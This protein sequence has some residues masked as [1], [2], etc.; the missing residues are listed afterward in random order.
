[1]TITT[2]P[3]HA[4]G[5]IRYKKIKPYPPSVEVNVDADM[6]TNVKLTNSSHYMQFGG[7]EKYCEFTGEKRMEFANQITDDYASTRGGCSSSNNRKEPSRITSTGTRIQLILLDEANHR[8]SFTIGSST[9]LKA[10]FNDYSHE[11]GISLRSL[12]FSHHGR[13]LFLSSVGKKTPEELNMSDQDIIDVF[14]VS[15]A[16]DDTT[17]SSQGSKKVSSRTARKPK[18]TTKKPK[19]NGKKK[20]KQNNQRESTKSLEEYKVEHS[21]VLSKLHKEAEPTL[22]EIRTRLNSLDLY[23]QPPK[24]KKSKRRS[25]SNQE[26]SSNNQ[27]LP[28]SGVGGKAGKPCYSVQVGEVQNLYKTSKKPSQSEN[29]RSNNSSTLDLHGYT[30]KEAITKL[31]ENLTTWVDTAMQGYYPFVMQVKIICGCGNQLLSEVVESWIREHEQ[32]ANCPKGQCV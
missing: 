22:K 2:N 15:Q 18:D 24:Q 1:M 4:N 30:Q 17:S 6:N 14:G 13:T 32:V 3:T 19:G 21:C 11:R 31:N 5:C 23:R 8:H 28:M 10:L 16:T 27:V 29:S 25:Q 20:K 26:Q 7:P 9:T 12:R